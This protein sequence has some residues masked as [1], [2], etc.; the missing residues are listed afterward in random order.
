[1]Q[2][3]ETPGDSDVHEIWEPRKWE[4]PDALP[5]PVWRGELTD[6]WGGVVSRI[7]LARREGGSLAEGRPIHLLRLVQRTRWPEWGGSGWAHMAEV[8][9]L[10]VSQSHK[11]ETHGGTVSFSQLRSPSQRA[12][13]III[14]FSAWQFLQLNCFHL[15]ADSCLSLL[16]QRG[17]TR[18][19]NWSILFI[20]I[21]AALKCR[22]HSIKYLYNGWINK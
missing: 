1:M 11:E 4:K 3:W 20:F 21:S 14:W 17:S 13:L 16:W 15:L 18:T 12:I 7:T 10:Q 6:W 8:L 5:P 22:K 19:G 9:I 2:F